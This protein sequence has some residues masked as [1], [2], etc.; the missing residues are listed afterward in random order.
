VCMQSPRAAPPLVPITRNGDLMPRPIFTV[1]LSVAALA[2]FQDVYAYPD[3]PVR[4][5]V[6]FNP[7]GGADITIRTMSDALRQQLGQPLVVENRPGGST[8]IGTDLVAKARPDGH[9]L[10]IVTS[11]F[12]INPSL[13]AKLP[14][15]PLE[16]LAPVA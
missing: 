12:A 8:I 2:S 3:H 7:G 14:Y 4:V 9:T 5:I 15:D 10:L 1:A 11:T 16:D 6:P 13:H